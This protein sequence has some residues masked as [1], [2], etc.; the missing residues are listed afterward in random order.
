MRLKKYVPLLMLSIF[1][2]ALL[3][4]KVNYNSTTH[5][6]NFFK[7]YKPSAGSANFSLVYDSLDLDLKGL[8]YNAFDYAIEGFEKLKDDGALSN[9]SILTIIDFDQPSYQKRMYVIDVKNIKILFNNLV[10]H[11]KNTGKEIAEFFSNTQESHKSSLG[12]YVTSNTYYGSK[13]FS[14]K[15]I[16]LERNINNNAL[17]RAIVMHGA[18]YVSQ[19]FINAQGYIG[20]SHGCPAVPPE[21]NTPIIEKIKN[22]S[23][24]FIY[25]KSYHPSTHFK[26]G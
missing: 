6:I 9:D 12:F 2:V 5:K 22:G 17:S 7:A 19:S 18:P 4:W 15:L 21:L 16:G 26:I 25:N 11:G 8:S 24:L 10:A 3:S 13:G 20:R 1:S 14:M 23:C